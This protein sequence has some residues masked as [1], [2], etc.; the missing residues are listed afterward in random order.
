MQYM[1]QRSRWIT[2]QYSQ[3]CGSALIWAR[4][5]IVSKPTIENKK[6]IFQIVQKNLWKVKNVEMLS[7]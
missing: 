7:T 2:E 1:N 5:Y 3:Q 4:F 6:L